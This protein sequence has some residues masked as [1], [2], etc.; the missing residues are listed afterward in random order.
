MTK[1]RF[2]KFDI[3]KQ[4]H[5]DELLELKTIE[6][7]KIKLKQIFVQ[8]IQSLKDDKALWNND[9]KRYD[10]IENILLSFLSDYVQ[11]IQKNIKDDLKIS[12]L[13]QVAYEIFKSS[14]EEKLTKKQSIEKMSDVFNRHTIDSP[15]FR[16]KIL[17]L[18]DVKLA[19]NY[20]IWNFYS[21]YSH[22]YSVF[23][24]KEVMNIKSTVV[25]FGR[26]PMS[27]SQ[28]DGQVFDRQKSGATTDVHPVIFDMYQKQED[29]FQITEEEMQAIMKGES[30][31]NQPP[32]KREEQIRQKMEQDRRERIEKVMNREL[33]VLNEEIQEKLIVIKEE[34]EAL[35]NK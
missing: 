31:L 7:Q 16:V 12:V 20:L 5:V 25:N 10:E 15:P 28:N 29:E 34:N 19:S 30:S 2:F 14:F 27:L 3:V 32:K 24:K 26:M 22:F 33:K 35:L 1:S 17:D 13:I 23:S 9:P 4:N 21:W 6:Q 8:Y 11:N 18:S